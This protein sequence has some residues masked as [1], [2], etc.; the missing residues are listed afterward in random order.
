MSPALTAAPTQSQTGQASWYRAAPYGV[1]AH[2][3]LPMGT[4]VR[5]T[6]LANGRSTS[7]RVGDRGPFVRGWIIDLARGTFAELAPPS[8]GV[9]SVRIEW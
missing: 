5:V 8:T 2:R 7:C 3:T 1:C 6:N 9:I 4:V